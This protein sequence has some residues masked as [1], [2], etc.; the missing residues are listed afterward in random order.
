LAACGSDDAEGDSGSGSGGGSTEV[1]LMAYPGQSYRL[2]FLVADQEGIFEDHGISMK[3]V[4]QPNNLTGTQGMAAT[5][6]NFGFLSTTTLVQGFQAGQTY[7]FVCGGI[8]VLQT[9]LIADTDSDLAST[10]DGASWEEVLK[11]LEGKTIGIQTPVGSGLQILFSAALEEAGV[12]EDDVTLV[13]LGGTPTTVQ[14]ALQNGSVDVAQI[15][16]PGN[17]LLETQ[18]YGKP[19]VYLPEGPQ[20][21][22]DNWGSG[23]VVDPA[24]FEGNGD[25]AADFCDAYQ[26]ALAWIQDEANADAAAGILAK[27]TGVPEDAAKLVVTNTFGDFVAEMDDDAMQATFDQYVDLGI[28]K[29]DPAPTTEELVV[30]P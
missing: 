15:N 29:A 11:G 21:Y 8:D 19:L 12:G 5:K 14:A 7:P 16:P 27:D 26:E 3:F 6:A 9:T 18:G 1:T 24:W 13:N 23:L 25:V 28:A 20:V 10:E 2:P 22:A 30:R 17:E 4:D